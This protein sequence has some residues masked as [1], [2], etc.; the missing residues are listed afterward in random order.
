[1]GIWNPKHRCII[2][3][4]Y[5]RKGHDATAE[6]LA[7]DSERLEA[8]ITAAVGPLDGEMGDLASK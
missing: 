4:A 8:E 1:M 7:L 3:V 2:T 5:A 6:S